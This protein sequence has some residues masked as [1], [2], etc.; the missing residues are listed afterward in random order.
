MAEESRVRSRRV[1]G[2]RLYCHRSPEYTGP[3]GVH[4]QAGWLP[5]RRYRSAAAFQSPGRALHACAPTADLRESATLGSGA[6]HPTA[7]S[8][9][10]RLSSSQLSRTPGTTCFSISL[11]QSSSRSTPATH[12]ADAFERTEMRFGAPRGK[13]KRKVRGLAGFEVC[14]RAASRSARHY[15][16]GGARV[17]G[18]LPVRM[19]GQALEAVASR[20]KSWNEGWYRAFTDKLPDSF[21]TALRRL[22][23][24]DVSLRRVNRTPLAPFRCADARNETAVTTASG[25]PEV[26]AHTV[27][28]SRAGK[29]A[30]STGRVVDR[31][32]TSRNYDVR[33]QKRFIRKCELRRRGPERLSRALE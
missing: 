30:H 4:A 27:T 22:S 26:S 20:P 13:A 14:V 21:D 29:H 1:S 12:F 2:Q 3:L 6:T 11:F 19:I 10:R 24:C 25:P 8:A 31:R 17:G 23:P 9:K 32:L 7:S 18:R 15:A 16:I 33:T 5:I 28:A